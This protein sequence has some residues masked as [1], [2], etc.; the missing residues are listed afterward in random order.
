VEIS[1]LSDIKN[2]KKR[3]KEVKTSGKSMENDGILDRILAILIYG[4][5]GDENGFEI[6]K[7]KN[8][9]AELE[10]IFDRF[11]K[12]WA[13]ENLETEFEELCKKRKGKSVEMEIKDLNDELAKLS[14]DEEDKINE[15]L[16]KIQDLQKTERE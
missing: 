5:V 16:K 12:G 7:E 11:Y 3:L 6:P 2:G 9:L 1:D 8:K 14:D 10:M 4:K 15:I 13:K